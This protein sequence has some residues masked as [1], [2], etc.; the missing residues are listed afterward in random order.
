MG[1]S[2]SSARAMVSLCRSPPENLL[3]AFPALVSYP[4]GRLLIKSWML[5][6]VQ[7][8]SISSSVASSF[9]IFRFS[10]ML[11]LNKKFSCDTYVTSCMFRSKLM[12]PMSA[13]PMV[14]CPLS[15]FQKPAS[16]F[17]MVDLPLPEDPT[18]AVSSPSIA[19]KFNPSNTFVSFLAAAPAVSH[20]VPP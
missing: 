11:L 16:S 4:L 18:I 9:A 14:M 5:A 2:L 17:A 3:P 15:I 12:L 1:L 8:V 19:V 7:A 6:F 20:S 10:R 13:P